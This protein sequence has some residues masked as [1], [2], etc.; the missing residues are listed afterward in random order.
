MGPIKGMDKE[1]IGPVRPGLGERAVR[2]AE[3]MKGKR[4]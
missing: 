1:I 4:V 2:K 3:K